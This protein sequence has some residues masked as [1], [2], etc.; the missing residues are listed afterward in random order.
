MKSMQYVCETFLWLYP[1]NGSW[2]FVSIDT[3]LSKEIKQNH[4]MVRRGFGSIRVEATIGKTTW[5]T[6][7][8]P[9]SKTNEYLLPIKASV[10][11]AENIKDGD[12]VKVT[13]DIPL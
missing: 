5:K 9:D 7:I 10:R 3:N 13:L 8:F 2:H 1:G 6:S 4:G 11:K 12:K